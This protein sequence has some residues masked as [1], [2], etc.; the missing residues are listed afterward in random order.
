M[1]QTD[2]THQELESLLKKIGRTFQTGFEP[3]QLEEQTMQALT[4][5]N[6][7]SHLSGLIRKGRI[8]NPLRDLPL[9][10]KVWPSSFILGRFLRRFEPAGKSL[11]DIGCGMG[12]C[13]LVA[14][15]Y[16]FARVV[17]A[18][19]DTSALDFARANVLRNGLQD[20][21]E[22]RM[23]DV[24]QP[25][26]ES[27]FSERFDLIAASELLYLD[28]LHAPLLRFLD[29]HLN[30]DGKAV[31]CT[32]LARKKPAFGALASRDF[33]VQ[34]GNVRVKTHLEDGSQEK[35]VYNLLILERK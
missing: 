17:L 15:Q 22:T 5:T 13:G 9:W 20:R 8:K 1:Q 16:G 29:A 28:K 26:A 33:A 14:S 27:N 2:T 35:R 4:I 3:L 25:A 6:M 32:D 21:I 18:D 23:L 19:I 31:F 30:E 10:A 11:L 7:K 12:T 24:S 34:E